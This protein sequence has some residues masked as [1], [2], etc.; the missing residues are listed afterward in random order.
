MSPPFFDLLY[1]LT[2]SHQH[3]GSILAPYILWSA[4]GQVSFT[5]L[6]SPPEVRSSFTLL[7]SSLLQKQFMKQDY[8]KES[9]V[10][11]TRK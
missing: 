9:N 7:W 6:L 8:V 5:S 3:L 1:V 11:Y 10:D 4:T 2:N